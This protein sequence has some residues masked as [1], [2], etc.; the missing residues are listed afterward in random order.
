MYIFK[1][2]FLKNFEHVVILQFSVG[3]WLHRDSPENAVMFSL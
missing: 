3:V 1:A 2:I